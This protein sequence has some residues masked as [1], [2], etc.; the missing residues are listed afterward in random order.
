MIEKK[1]TLQLAHFPRSAKL[2]LAA[3]LL[4]NLFSIGQLLYRFTLPSDGWG[5]VEPDGFEAL[6]L[7][8]QENVL[9]VDSGLQ[10]GDWVT[11]VDDTLIDYGEISPP[12]GLRNAWRAGN[13]VQYTVQRREHTLT[14]DVP[15]VPGEMWPWIQTAVFR[16]LASLFYYVGTAVFVAISYYTFWQR[17]DNPA[18][19]ALLMMASFLL[20]SLLALDILPQRLADHYNPIASFSVTVLI[21][22]T[23]SLLLPPAFIRFGL[24]FPHPKPILSRW[25]WLEYLPYLVGTAVLI[26]FLNE[27]FVWGWAWTGSA[28]LLCLL[29]LLHNAWT[30][31]DA[32]SRGQLRWALGGATL[33]MGLFLL[34]YIGVFFAESSTSPMGQL[35]TSL[36]QL[37]FSI[38]GISLAVAVL[39][40]SLFGI[41]RIVNR[42]LVFA[43][44]TFCVVTLY[45]LVVGYLS[46]L[47]QTEANLTISLIATGIVAVLFDRIRRYLQRGVNR[48]MYGDR[49]EPYQVLTQLGQQ[50]E[51][52][53]EPATALART[54]ETVARALK[55]PYS[56][57]LLHQ[58]H[59]GLTPSASYGKPQPDVERFPLIYGGDSIGELIVG[60]RATDEP[61]T[62]SDQHLLTDLA[63]QTAVMAQT[64]RVTADLEQARLR[65]VT[66]RGEARR[67]LGSDL[68]DGVG[69]QLVGLS[70]QLERVTNW[71]SADSEQTKSQLTEINLQL[72]LL[73]KKVRSMAHQLFPP[74]LELL[75]LVGAIQ[76]QL[77]MIHGLQIS[78]D[79]PQRLPPLP[80][81]IETAAYYITLE[82]LTNIEKHAK[83]QAC[84]IRLELV[85]HSHLELDISDDGCGLSPSSASGLGLL[86]MQAR[87]ADLGGS[88]QISPQADGGT[89]VRVRIPCL[90]SV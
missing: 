68:H 73:T 23:F 10:A 85:S 35:L 43:G 22:G 77:H 75:G 28:V 41:D 11:A 42:V 86:S 56:A 18:A 62:P 51:N 17:P 87:A 6:G 12:A 21:L 89:A 5:A 57:V 34:N 55:L 8:Y 50:I 46:F 47:F 31:R 27:Q 40:Y 82:A 25:P 76:E 88:C 38:M 39:R 2:L 79:T 19:Q 32:V 84:Y 30:M 70:R 64:L 13:T 80:A 65:L 36:S 49:D 72:D 59:D 52:S 58:D 48:L 69:H 9:G 61:L 71:L 1:G 33:G 66:E 7:I 74:E 15:L 63:R 24:V 53:L 37:S 45:V 4:L 3:V 78:F 14:I 20:N 81:E 54:A 16:D 90:F 67:K 26:A 44:L 29:L 60:L 83:A